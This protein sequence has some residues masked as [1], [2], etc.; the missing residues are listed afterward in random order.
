MR[1][2]CAIVYWS[3]AV[4]A[5]APQATMTARS[6]VSASA[7]LTHAKMCEKNL[8]H[9]LAPQQKEVACNC[10]VYSKVNVAFIDDH[11]Y[12]YHLI[13]EWSRNHL[14][15]LLV[16]ESGLESSFAINRTY[17]V[18]RSSQSCIDLV[19]TSTSLAR[20][21]LNFNFITRTPMYYVHCILAENQ[22]AISSSTIKL[23]QKLQ[24]ANVI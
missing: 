12:F 14:Y 23:M 21:R 7:L 11:L 24:H 4:G 20:M 9:L 2:F 19:G 13:M 6:F 8:V 16:L 18:T 10:E 1:C 22:V 5:H 17:V 15:D 3:A